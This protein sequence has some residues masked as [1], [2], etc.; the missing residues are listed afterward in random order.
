MSYAMVSTARAGLSK[1]WETHRQ[2]HAVEV[3][4]KQRQVLDKLLIAGVALRVCGL[5]VHVQGDDV[6]NRCQ[7]LGEHLDQLLVVRGDL[8]GA[9]CL[10]T[11]NLGQALQR[12]VPELWYLEEPRPER[13]DQGGLE[14][15]SQG[16]PVAEAQERLQGGLDKARL[17]GAVEDLLA[18]LEDLRELGTHGRLEVAGFC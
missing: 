7:D 14:D 8:A 2:M 9:C 11:A 5:E 17:G 18:E 4:Q 12:D 13:V 10:Q 6:G 1:R 16:N 15:V 3:A